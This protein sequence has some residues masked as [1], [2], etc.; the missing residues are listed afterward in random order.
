MSIQ[1]TT[2]TF[3][4]F[5]DYHQIYLEDSQAHNLIDDPNAWA[6]QLLNEDALARHL[7]IA[8]G[9]LCLLTARPMTVPV[10]VEVLRQA[11]P[12]DLAGWDHVAEASLAV[13]SGEVVLHGAT[14]YLP[15]APHLAVEPG[16]YRVRACAGGLDTLSP[17][18]LEGEDHY[19]L[20]LWPAP[21]R[22]PVLLLARPYPW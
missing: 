2:Q 7:G 4:L 13:P 9:V 16:T 18:Q 10:E 3:H 12:G 11:P 19:K 1:S 17:D 14:D 21:E 8:S 20:T 6:A 22:E 15:D 5:A